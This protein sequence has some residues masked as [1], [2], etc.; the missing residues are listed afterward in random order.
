[1]PVL[2]Q[3]E[4]GE[5]LITV[6]ETIFFNIIE[7][8]KLAILIPAILPLDNLLPLITSPSFTMMS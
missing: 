3:N 6:I 7:L 5:L 1:M 4:C 8:I 2:N